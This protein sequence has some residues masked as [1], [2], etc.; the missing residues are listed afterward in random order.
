MKTG[1]FNLLIISI[2]ATSTFAAELRTWTSKSGSTV[3]ARFVAKDKYNVTLEDESGKK[4]QIQTTNLA[5]TDIN[6]LDRL[7]AIKDFEKT[8]KDSAFILRGKVS[9]IID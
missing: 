4:M 5:E 3:V 9:Q 2:F 6:Y 7:D 8:L 1:L